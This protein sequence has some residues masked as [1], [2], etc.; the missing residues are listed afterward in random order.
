[1]RILV[2][3]PTRGRPDKFS[4]TFARYV[5]YADDPSNIHFL[6]TMDADDKTV[7]M[8]LINRTIEKHA[9][10]QIFVG[11][12]GNKIAAVNRDMQYAPPFD[13]LLLASDDMVPQV[14][15]YDTIIRK[16]MQ[17]HF[18]DTDGVLWFNDGHQGHRLNT[19]CILGRKYY[20]RFGYIYNPAYRTI[21]CDNEFMETANKL[22]RQVYDSR[23]IIKHMHPDFGHSSV[24]ATYNK[25]LAGVDD[26]RRTYLRRKARGTGIYLPIVRIRA[27]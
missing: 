2:K 27:L 26:D 17:E 23:V 20:Q 18:P 13:I 7:T 4:D 1:M 21:Y 22:R 9:S 25:N 10:T 24:D 12:S 6:V 5:E 14:R 8:D 19:L 16:K 11:H 15:G 3:F